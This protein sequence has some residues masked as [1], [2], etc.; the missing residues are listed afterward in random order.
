[1]FYGDVRKYFI[2]REDFKHAV[3]SRCDEKDSMTILRSCLGPEPGKLIEGISSDLNSAWK[4]LDQNDGDPRV[5][6]DI[7]SGD[8]ENFNAI[9][10]GEDNR[11]CDLVNLVRRS[12]NILKE[13]KRPQDIDNTHVISL[14]ER[15][16]TKDD[17]K[18]WARHI[19]LQKLEPSMSNLLQWME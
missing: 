11:F 2:F 15:K 8:L 1:M 3:E 10:P 7:V 5:I 17:L 14:I 6:S 13:V 12:D 18:V 9:Q 19:Y 16:M 4:Y